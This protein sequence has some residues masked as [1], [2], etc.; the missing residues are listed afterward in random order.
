MQVVLVM[1]RADG[2]RRSFSIHRDI[3]VIGRREDCDFRI[4]LGEVS[5]KHCRVIKNGQTVKVEDLG[6]SNG[7]FCNGMRVQ[8]ADLNPGDTLQVGPAVFVVQI[9]GAPNEDEMAPITA[10]AAAA[11][12]AAD[13]AASP[14][15]EAAEV[16]EA[17]VEASESNE[18]TEGEPQT[19]I[20]DRHG[21][22]GGG[23]NGE[24]DPM[25]VLE[26]NDES[27]V[28][29]ALGDSALG[30]EDA[31]HNSGS[32]ADIDVDASEESH[33]QNA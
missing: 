16:E 19:I 7:T 32:A 20:S 30:G 11:V 18:T 31:N 26:G 14:S 12:A 33:Q 10:E 2:E 15:S 23:G 3:T 8:E 21:G 5:R 24:F 22:G 29:P 25:S 6:S 17:L 9:D 27:G 28:M 13:A 4:P 1:F